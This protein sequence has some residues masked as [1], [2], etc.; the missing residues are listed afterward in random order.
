VTRLYRERRQDQLV[1]LLLMQQR[2]AP[3]MKHHS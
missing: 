3:A 1:V 2:Q